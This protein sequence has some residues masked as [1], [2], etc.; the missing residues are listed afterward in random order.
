L[1]DSNYDTAVEM[2]ESSDYQPQPVQ[3]IQPTMQGNTPQHIAAR[4]FAQSFGLHP[5]MALLTVILDAM[6][7]GGQIGTLEAIYPIVIA[8]AFGLGIVTFMAQ[9]KWYGDD[10]ESAFIKAFIVAGLTAIPTSLPGFLCIAP[11]LVG[12]FRKS[13]R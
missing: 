9:K 7:F 13:E 8:S 12:F 4:G 3:T 6:L 1:R 11:G 10:N 2:H 5:G